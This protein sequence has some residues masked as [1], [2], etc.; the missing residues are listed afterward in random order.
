MGQDRE[1]ANAEGVLIPLPQAAKQMGMTVEALTR[2]VTSGELKAIKTPSGET[3]VLESETDT[4]I[5]DS[6]SFECSILV[7]HRRKVR[8]FEPA[9]HKPLT[10]DPGFS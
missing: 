6:H 7:A 9:R 5:T 3:V 10:A 2:L 8:Q 4:T 1:N